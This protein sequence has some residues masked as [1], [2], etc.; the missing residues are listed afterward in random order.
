MIVVGIVATGPE[1]NIPQ[2]THYK[3]DIDIWIG[4]DRGAFILIEQE[5][6]V[7]YAVGDFDS[8]TEEERAVIDH[9]A[10][11]VTQ[12]PAEKDETDLELAVKQAI[13]LNAS[14][15][16]FFG[17]TGGRLDHT[18]VNV[19]FLYSLLNRDIK[20]IIIDKSNYLELVQDGTYEIKRRP[21]FPYVSFI[22]FTEKVRGISLE[23]FYYTTKD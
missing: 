6:D 11:Q 19:Q 20:G 8:A 1:E 2:L 3:Q 9:K 18:M 17:V 5:V 12:V 13:E 23:G 14:S 16:Y 21:L 4:A 22:P 15:I 10:L 7:H